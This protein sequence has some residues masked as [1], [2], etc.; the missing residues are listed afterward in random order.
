MAHPVT[1]SK[2]KL[3][4]YAQCPRRL[5]LG[6]YR[7]ELEDETMA[8]HAAVETGRAVGAKAREVYGRGGGHYVA[9]HRGLR[10]ATV[11]T[12]ELLA[13]GGDEPIFEATFDYA[14]LTMQVDVLDRSGGTLRIV[15]VKSSTAVKEH[16]VTDCAIQAW[17]LAGLGMPASQVALAHVND[18]FVYGANG[19]YSG[20]FVEEDLTAAAEERF[21][22]LRTLAANARATLEAHEEPAIA[23]G[24]QCN[25]PYACPFFAHCAPPQG[26]YP[27]TVLGGLKARL[28]ALM[29]EGYRD[30][31]DIPEARLTNEL[32]MRI[33]KQTKLGRPYVG[34]ELRDAARA[35]AR[36]RY[37][38]D[39]ETIAFAIPIWQGTRPYEALPFQWSVHIDD[40]GADESSNGLGHAAFLSLS[41]EPP[42]RA[43]AETL[44]ETLGR[45]GPVVVYSGYEK[46]VLNELVARFPDLDA[47]LAAIRGRLV[48]L[49]P[50]VKAHYYHPDMRGSWSLKA[51]ARAVSSALDYDK[52]GEV[53]D[54]ETAQSAY[55][56]AIRPTTAPERRETLRRDLLEYCRHDTLA[57]VELVAHFAGA[58]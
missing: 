40:A 8:E 34:A 13:T 5:W 35:L 49:L 42:M 4:A 25:K 52:L 15:E 3:L 11:A 18:A 10:A 41:G 21:D 16:H 32:E 45:S 30:V 38:L 53:R 58:A 39:F 36:P 24:E 54:G 46:R 19:D 50:L 12:R 51:V 57:L 23:I 55:L 7:P 37:Y 56:E 22:A 2:T 47:P 26:E 1:L 20:L 29:R 48:D 27:V 43:C 17:V 9:G 28:Y 33:V 31:R 44:I 6:Q 14:G